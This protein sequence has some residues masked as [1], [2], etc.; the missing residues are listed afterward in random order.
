MF[1]GIIINN[2][3]SSE[4]TN[5]QDLFYK[6]YLLFSS[7]GCEHPQLLFGIAMQVNMWKGTPPTDPDHRKVCLFRE[8]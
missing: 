3:Y 2:Y 4:L 8:E 1:M 5:N 7:Q 6:S